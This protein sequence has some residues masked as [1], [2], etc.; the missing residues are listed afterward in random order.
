MP[1]NGSKSPEI[2]ACAYCRAKFEVNPLFP[3][4]RFCKDTCRK[5]SHRYGSMAV[6]K[7]AEKTIRDVHKLFEKELAPLRARV[8]ALEEWADLSARTGQPHEVFPVVAHVERER[9]V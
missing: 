1:V 6:G 3:R 7:I 4:K 2:R 9:T 5:L 8:E